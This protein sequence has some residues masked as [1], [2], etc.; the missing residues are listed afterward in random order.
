[1]EH[2]PADFD[3][4][5]RGHV[6]LVDE[7]DIRLLE[8]HGGPDLRSF[9]DKLWE[10]HQTGELTV[11]IADVNQYP[12]GQIVIH[13]SGKPAHSEFPDQQSLRVHPAF[14]GF[15]LGTCLI[16]ASERLVAAQGYSHVGLSVG[17]ENHKARRLYER[18][19]YSVIGTEYEDV[20]SYTDFAGVEIV[21]REMVLDLVKKLNPD[22]EDFSSA[23][24]HK[25]AL[26]SPVVEAIGVK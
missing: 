14:R 23:A 1:M 11:L 16:K 26:P 12:V 21:L 7:T 15:G 19:G 22:V 9:Y 25:T 18:L 2:L 6:R 13:W 10:G 5:G 4:L 3:F 24:L 17:V 20:W 8:W